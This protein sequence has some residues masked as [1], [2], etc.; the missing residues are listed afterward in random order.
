MHP[1]L[2]S[3]MSSDLDFGALPADPKDCS[4]LLQVSIGSG[5]GDGADIFSVEVITPAAVARLPSPMWLRHHLLLEEFSWLG[6]EA[7]IQKLLSHCSG[8]DWEEISTK[9]SRYLHW[10]FEDYG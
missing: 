3:I 9:L 7:A 5:V 10:E 4:V 1:R 8:S 6:V 2:K